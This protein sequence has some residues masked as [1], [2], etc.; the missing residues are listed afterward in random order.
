MNSGTGDPVWRSD[1]PAE[2]IAIIAA[3][4]LEAAIPKR[5]AGNRCPP[6]YVSGP[7]SE[8]A[9]TAARRAISDGASAL[10]SWGL[11]GGLTESVATGT[12]VVPDLLVSGAGQW[13][14]NAAW[15][16]RLLDALGSRF[17]L[18]DGPLYTADRVIT[19]LED[20][21]RLASSTGSVAVDMESA[22]VA[23][24]AAEDSIPFVALRV[25]ADG[26]K[27][28]LPDN[29]AAL[30]TPSGRTRYRGLLGFLFSPRRLKLLVALAG[31]S[32]DARQQLEAVMRELVQTDDR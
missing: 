13:Q 14:A 11:A 23:E 30:I 21:S 6:V 17:G 12:I 32:R 4:E 18:S 5:F 20:K 26:P 27:D 19:T 29:A 24:A 7:G 10:M 31:R 8:R 1:S 2:R 9:F 15:R 22:G 3:L 25:V 16:Q 28:E